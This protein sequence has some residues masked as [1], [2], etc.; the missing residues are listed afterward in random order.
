MNLP[1]PVE[2]W[3]S[4]EKNVLL[5]SSRISVG[6]NKVIAHPFNKLEMMWAVFI[7][8]SQPPMAL[9]EFCDRFFLDRRSG[10]EFA[11]AHS[12]RL[13]KDAADD[14]FVSIRASLFSHFPKE[15]LCIGQF[16]K[17]SA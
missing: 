16:Q 17:T 3:C 7:V 8:Q 15:L 12:M 9:H 10:Y 6:I 13:T 14:S 2:F 11:K 1:W 4:S 5:I